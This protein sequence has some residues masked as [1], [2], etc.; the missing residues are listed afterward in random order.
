[1]TDPIADMLTRIRNAQMAGKSEV[2]VPFSK[3]KFDVA[4]ILLKQGYLGN[5][6]KIDDNAPEILIEIKYKGKKEPVIKSLKRVS[7]V[8]CRVYAK[9][10]QIPKVLNGHGISI[11][12]TSKGL[13]TNTEAQKNGVGGE[14]ICEVY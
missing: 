1:M 11:L 2:A 7:K 9:K 13:M 6:K 10:D 3:I 14:I 5:V 12:S 8:G 4:Q